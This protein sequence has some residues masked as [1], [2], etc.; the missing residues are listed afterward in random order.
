MMGFVILIFNVARADFSALFCIQSKSK[1]F[2][3]FLLR[4]LMLKFDIN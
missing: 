2:D 4:L 1:F 3:N